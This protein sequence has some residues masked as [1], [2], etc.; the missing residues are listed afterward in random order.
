[1]KV[2]AGTV[3]LVA[4]VGACS[5]APTVA[6]Y[7]TCTTADVCPSQTVC[8]SAV[9]TS[10]T[11]TLPFCTYSCALPTELSSG[12]S[13]PSDPSGNAAVCLMTGSLS[14][15]MGNQYGFCFQGCSTGS[16][17]SGEMCATIAQDV[18]DV[19]GMGICIPGLS[20]PLSGTSWQSTTIVPVAAGSGVIAS[21]YA[22][23]FASGTATYDPRNYDDAVFGAS[24]PFTATFTQTYSTSANPYGGC[25]ETTTFS[26]GI[27]KDNTTLS[28]EESV[29]VTSAVGTTTRTGCATSSDNATGVMGLYDDAVTSGGDIFVVTGNTL[30]L[31]GMGVTPYDGDTPWTFT[32]M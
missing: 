14:G 23:T 20:D 31:D 6:R 16:C 2:W 24:G 1:M 21:T 11:N 22:V 15:T 5:A 3:T 13:C 26:G 4:L 25:V 27:W 28:T 32:K 9:T 19:G 12:S 10:T 8:E 17:P 30:Q 7:A 18:T 29:S